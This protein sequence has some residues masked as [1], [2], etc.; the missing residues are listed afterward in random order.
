MEMESKVVLITGGNSGIGRATAEG[1]AFL[2]AT[3]V[4]VC[5]NSERGQKTLQEIV[6]KSKNNQVFLFLTDLSLQSEILSLRDQFRD[7]F[8]RLDI[9]V[10]NAGVYLPSVEITRE[11]LEK[12]LAT[13]H[14]AYFLL[15][16]TL[17]SHL[18]KSTEGRII[19]VSSEAHRGI[20]PDFAYYSGETKYAGW[21]AYQ[22]TKLANLLFTYYLA[23]LLKNEDI[24]VNALHPG[25]VRT[26][27]ARS[28]KIIGLLWRM[29]PFF[30]SPIKAA[31]T[32][33][34]LAVSSEQKGKTGL[35]FSNKKPIQSSPQS[36]DKTHQKKLWMITESLI[37]NN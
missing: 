36:L 8:E 15:T 9:L 22:Q 25:V 7:Q 31:Q 17:L 11:G 33:L 21:K 18:R 27:I 28:R 30:I 35:Y 13:N 12:T 29:M 3:V 1:L 10:N 14:V 24:T 23:D 5:R 2:G 19:N 34:Y 6:K 20:D 37:I 32:P 16:K 26:N 4:I